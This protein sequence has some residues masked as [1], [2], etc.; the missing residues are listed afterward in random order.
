MSFD[1]VIHIQRIRIIVHTFIE[2]SRS[3]LK[4]DKMRLRL[5]KGMKLELFYY[6]NKSSE[7][8]I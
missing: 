1:S 3:K 4:T 5:V 8:D 6:Y 7:V 2:K